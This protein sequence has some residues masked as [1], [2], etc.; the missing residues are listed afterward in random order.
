MSLEDGQKLYTPKKSLVYKLN[1]E[2]KE[3]QFIELREPKMSHS[4]GYNKISQMVSGLTASSALK[5]QA[6]GIEPEENTSGGEVKKLHEVNQDEYESEA[7]KFAGMLASLFG[8]SEDENLQANFV[9]TFRDMACRTGNASICVVDG[10]EPMTRGIWDEM[11]PEDGL[12]MALAWASF[13]TMPPELEK[14][15]ESDSASE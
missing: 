14:P 6:L 7:E 1:G 11:S 5:M 4:R 12:G 10:E 3:A 9:D 15:K 2:T 13:F 8:F